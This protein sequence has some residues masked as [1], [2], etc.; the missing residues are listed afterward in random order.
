MRTGF[1]FLG[2]IVACGP[3]ELYSIDP[4]APRT[5]SGNP[6]MDAGPGIDGGPGF[7]AGPGID[8]GPGNDAGLPDVGLDAGPPEGELV[9]GLEVTGLATFQNVRVSVV[10]NGTIATHEAPIIAGK[11][12][13]VRVYVRPEAGWS[14]RPVTARLELTNGGDTQVFTDQATIASTSSD[15]QPNTVFQIAVPGDALQVDTQVSVQLTEPGGT[16]GDSARFPRDGSTFALNAA[17]NGGLDVVV[18]PIQYNADGSGRVPD[19]SAAAMDALRAHMLALFPVSEVRLTVREPLPSNIP[20]S[21]LSGG[22]WSNTLNLLLSARQNDG[23]SDREYYLGLFNPAPSFSDYCRGGCIAGLAPLNDRNFGSQRGG[24]ALG[25]ADENNRFS[26]LHE[27]GHAMGRPHAPCGGVSGAEGAY[28]HSGGAIGVW[29]YDARD[30]QLFPPNVKDF[31]GYCD[32]QWISDWAVSRLHERAVA[33]AG[34][35][36]LSDRRTAHHLVTLA[37]FHRPIWGSVDEIPAREGDRLRMFEAL[38]ADGDVLGWVAVR[39][40]ALSDG[41]SNLLIPHTPNADAFRA[42]DGMI[43]RVPSKR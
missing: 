8:A 37:P 1:I 5:D 33:V 4:S 27:L 20:V 35:M 12:A 42:P 9:S 32:P 6:G 29:G 7:D 23:A 34:A 22:G 26:G 24:I 28:P 30:G 3:A 17:S 39:E 43:L 11:P 40:V 18:V 16:G 38:S 31:M 25:Y 21:A 10:S 13:L 2:L 41:G 15:D 19:T 14:A 36:A